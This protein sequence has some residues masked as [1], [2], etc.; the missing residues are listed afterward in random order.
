[1]SPVPGPALLAAALG[2]ALAT[3]PAPSTPP[4]PPAAPGAGERAVPVAPDGAAAAGTRWPADPVR[5]IQHAERRLREA[6]A[7]RLDAAALGGI[8][9]DYVDYQGLARRSLGRRW[10][11]LPAPDQAAVVAALRALLE[12]T[13][14]VGLQPGGEAAV[15]IRELRRAGPEADLAL[16]IT[17][18]SR[19]V[20]VELRL[21][22]VKGK[23]PPWQ[24]HDATV[25]GLAILEGY[26]EQLPQLLALGGVKR[27]LAQLEAERQVQLRRH[28]PAPPP[29][30]PPPAR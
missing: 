15:E 10:A 8:A 20:P 11:G 22:R 25:A 19:V 7:A 18:G 28:R 16:T 23:A 6:L 13:Y 1:M 4:P 29:S 30:P 3:A 2:A 26:Q 14:L 5:T 24:I 12:A 9:A 27:L 21:S 17:S